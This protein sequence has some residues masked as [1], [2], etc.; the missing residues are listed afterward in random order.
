MAQ[1]GPKELD[2]KQGPDEGSSDYKALVL[3]YLFGGA[4]TF[5]ML[6]PLD[7]QL[8]QEYMDIRRV[9][10]LT[11]EKLEVVTTSGQACQKFGIHK[12]LSI[13]KELYD[14]GDAAFVTNVGNLVEPILGMNGA[15]R[16]CPALFSHLDM[17]IAAQT[18][19][20]QAGA[21]FKNGGGGRMAD[22]LAK[23]DW[24]FNA[25]SF[26]LS[27]KA[28]WSE[29]ES[30][31]R[32]VISGASA[33]NGFN[34][35][36]EV[37]A[38]VDNLTRVEWQGMYAK[39]FQ[40]QYHLSI[41][42][43]RILAETLSGGDRLLRVGNND[44]GALGSLKQVARLIAAR[45]DRRANRDFFFVGM[46]HWDHHVALE[47]ELFARMGDVNRGVTAFVREMKA[48]GVW[49]QV[50]LATQSEFGRTFDPN[51][52]AGTDHG[53]AG[54]HF[55]LGGAVNGGKVYNKFPESLSRGNPADAGRGR[56]IP[57]YPYESYMV[58]IAK[59]LG[60]ADGQLNTL[61]PNYGNFNS[62]FIIP[63]LFR[64]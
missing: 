9:V 37:L 35:G 20:C 49:D 21:M 47:P 27:G 30:T 61:F 1:S 50:V 42:G 3:L 56:F 7:C 55:V 63:N 44:Y 6:V 4:D 33:L 48:Q 16:W 22:A 18:L 62:S 2:E 40:N 17:T 26:S 31:R 54:Q 52:G 45:G 53:W 38:I 13:V 39:E 14:A 29:G 36:K 57:K 19:K 51:G 15:R 64:Q 28:V 10:A 25:N 59:W 5:N 41:D 12:Q 8:Y 23:G 24:A 11:E 32:S 34:P 43:H 60:V 46:P 58:P